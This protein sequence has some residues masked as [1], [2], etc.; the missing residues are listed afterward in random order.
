L[1]T[2]VCVPLPADTDGAS[3][4]FVR[5]LTTN[6][7]NSDEWIG[8]DNVN[9][10]AT[11]GGGGPDPVAVTGPGDK[12]GTVGS[13]IAAF[14][15]AATGGTPPYSWSATGLPDGVSI[16]PST[17]EVSGTPTTACACAVTATATDDADPAGTDDAAFTFTISEAPPVVTI[18]DIQGT[19]STSPLAGTSVTTE[20][21]VTA[22]YRDP[23]FA[24]SSY[25]GM[26]I[27][28]AGTG[29]AT[30]TTPG[31]SDAVFVYGAN[32]MPVGIEVGDSVSVTG[33]V[34]EAFSTT[35]ITPAAGGVVELGAPLAPVTGLDIAYPTTEADREAQEGM[36][37]APTDT[38]TVTNSYN[39]NTFAEVGLATGTEPLVQPTEVYRD[40]APELQTVKD[41][42][43]ARG[44]VLDDGTSVNY[45]TNSAAKNQPLPWLTAAGGG[46]NVIRVGA[47]AT[48]HQPVIL[49]YRFSTWR[50]QPQTPLFGNGDAVAT[51]ANTRP[52]NETAQPVGG[53]LQIATFNVL[54]YFNTTGEAYDAL[55]NTGCTFYD[56]R[57]GNHIGNNQCG[58]PAASNG[59]GPRGAA[60]QVSFE[61]QQAKIVNAINTLDADI[62]GLEEVENS[63]K[64]L[65]ET[66]RDDAVSALVAALNA[67]AGSNKW[68]YVKSPGEALAS[69]AISEQD[70]I[71]PAFIYQPATVAPVG[72]SDILFGTTEFT[73][74]R[75][76]LAQ[77]FKPADAPDSEAF[78]VI[79]NHFKSKGDSTPP[80]TGDN[81][82]S[83]DVG[84][85][86]GDRT[87]QATRLAQFAQ[88]FADARGIDAIFLAGDFNAYTHEDP[89][90]ALYDAGFEAIDS[91]DPT[92]ESYS[93]GGL[94]G[95]LDH[96]LGNAA[97][98]ALVT[99]ADVWEINADESI[100][101]QYSRY[102]YNLTDFWQPNLPFAASDHNPEVV[103]IDLPAYTPDTTTKVQILGT[104]DFHGRLLANGQEGG[105][106]VL[107]GA[108]KELRTQY[109]NTVFA[110][111]GDL[112]G[113]STFESFIQNDEP[114]I[115][116]LN[117][118]GLEVSAAGNH[119]FD[120]GYE[121]F[122]G[123]IQTS[124]NWEYIAANVNEPV[125]RDDL[126]ET[127][128]QTFGDIQVGF[129]GAVTED[130]PAL[131]SPSGIAGV[132]VSD[133]VDSTNAAAA[134]L[135]TGGADIVVLLVHE[136]SPS[137]DC[138]SASFTDPSTVWGNITQNVSADV[139]AIISGH[140]HLAY[141]CSF[142]VDDWVT[143]AR[144]VTKRPVVSSGQYGSNLNQLIFSVDDA[145]DEVM[146]TSQDV[147]GLGGVGWTP[148]PAVTTIVNDAVAQAETLGAVKLGEI[149]GP[150]NRAKLSGGSTEN[151]GG[152][153][154]LGNL[155]AEVQRWATETPEAGAAQIAFM[156]PGGLRQDMAGTV[157]GSFRDLTY[158]QA[159]VVQPFANTL[160][161][162]DLT[163]AQLET[164]LEQQ[165]QRTSGGTV[166]S[167]PFLR[168]GASEG[169]TY[170]YVET[171]VVV[172][173]TNTFEG[174]VTGMWLDGVAIDPATT[175]SVTVNSFLSSGGDNFFEFVNGTSRADTGKVDLEAMVDY[176]AEFGPAGSPLPVDY[177]QRAVE[178]EFPGAAPATYAPGDSVSF[179]VS[180][181]TMSTADDVKDTEIQVKLGDT[182]LG[183]ATL[184][185][186]IGTAVYDAYGTAAV[187]V[188]LPAELADGDHEL[189]LVGQQTGTSVPVPFVAEDGLT[190]VQ[191]LG[192][193]DFH[194]RL[195]VDG[196][197][198]A[199]DCDDVACPAA[200]LSGAVK[201]LRTENPNTVFAAA[202][203]LVGAST[204]ESFIQNDEPTIDALNE[205]GLEVSAAGNHEF[206]QGY[207][208]LVGRIQTSANWEYL[209]ANVNEPVGRDDLAETWTK[210]FGDITVGFVGAVTEELPAL[211]SPA[212]IE[213]VTVTDIVDATNAAAVD[214]KA[215][216]ADIVV[217][218]V[219]EGSPSTDCGSANFTD[220]ATVWGNI[221]QNVSADVDAIVSGHTHLA[222]NCSF[223]VQDWVDES[224]AVTQRPVVSSGQYGQNLNQLVFTVEDSTGDVTAKTQSVLALT[225]ANFTEDP[226]VVT[227][228]HDA[229][230]QADVLG[231]EVL[232]QIEAPLNRAKLANGTTENRGGESTLG[233][234]VAEVQRWATDTPETGSAQIA[235]MNPGG[236]RQDMAGTVNGD[237]RDVTYK[238]AAVV[239]PFANTLVNMDLTGAQIETVLEQQWQ[240]TADGPSGTV[241]SRPFLRLGVS[242]GFT[243]T[244]VET[245]VTVNGVD[246]FQGEVTGMWLNEVAI[247][248]ATSYSVTVN[249]FLSSGGDNFR[250]FTGGAGKADTGKIDLQA[251][252]DYLDEF[253]PV[254][255]PLALDYSQRA[256]EVEAVANDYTVG[257]DLTFDVASWTM[258]TAADVKDSEIVVKLGDTVLGTAALDNT[259]GTA[260]FDTY[261]TAQV[262]LPIPGSTLAGP[263]TLTLVGESTG[264]E[265]IVPITLVKADSTVTGEDVD[266]VYGQGASMHVSVS[267]DGAVP[268]GRVTLR[269]GDV[270][271]G[272]AQLSGGEA[273]VPIVAE[274]VGPGT[275]D[276]TI[277]YLGDGSVKPSTSTATLTVTKATPTVIGTRTVMEYGSG[278]LM[279]VRVGAAGV[280]P[281]GQV[282]LRADGV[283]LGT[284]TLTDGVAAAT[285]LA[286]RLPPGTYE[287]TI[288]YQG[289][290]FVKSETG[291]ATLVVQKA[292]PTVIGVNTSM[293]FGQNGA[294]TVKVKATGVVPT[295][296]VSLTANGV[297]LGP[298]ATLVDGKVVATLVRNRLP[299]SATPYTVTIKYSGDGFVKA[300]TGTASLTVRP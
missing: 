84:A 59:N 235:F 49:E 240:R 117:E 126:A 211:V 14:T 250:A 92:D 157:N 143:E 141:N 183:T 162:M 290:E 270:G 190:D 227:I 220:P 99:A 39:T 207:E 205:A 206:D 165:W 65:T 163:G 83:A 57:A 138:S 23:A 251:M 121:D 285:I 11:D 287:V 293:T 148:D 267:A 38:F 244:Y 153:S 238:Q 142:T 258:S 214:L 6:A 281:T 118:A 167:R 55:P 257:G 179:D 241:P 297:S 271:L 160:V 269:V 146:A 36:L 149:Q 77:A 243:Y 256:V 259:I 225:E 194:G 177:S 245:P 280:V 103:G 135:K 147:V 15:M 105:A 201:E 232:G 224:R 213:G 63:M 192:T 212:G 131:V 125:G 209:A 264:T 43:L 93:F 182:V 169:F 25:D 204:F 139:D 275:H 228:V 108:V 73:N 263:A 217:L 42:N 46:P 127:W 300:G 45:L 37:L 68:A 265:V 292:T 119:E 54:N 128:T 101:F 140:T 79:V 260:V 24:S 69:T 5:V 41:D 134:D 48:L 202:G 278:S 174:E 97:A 164:V 200:I 253:G 27:Q 208:D 124:A 288:T 10:T 129:V 274:R 272:Q 82:N 294:M 132:T 60:T 136:G 218:L 247:D 248:P 189:T 286:K 8:I 184:N 12:T 35:E 9:I 196:A 58:T 283:A 81:A 90:H 161:N 50:F 19:G 100:A 152:E 13:P 56:D 96:F 52:A 175:Y 53:D 229:K 145:T 113:A 203:D 28:T 173:G 289:D 40:D 246:T 72:A 186:T 80:A 223:T 18:A 95:S 104:N 195:L 151:R 34:S 106:A 116:A 284:G 74:A 133:I 71:R 216:G 273:D 30:D 291:T 87:R 237:A 85:F 70:V 33:P 91:D 2:P 109:P 88:D 221:T 191:I 170:T 172:S 22:M 282:T 114:T 222:Y 188:T 255:T 178:V 276:V 242:E 20:G 150:F 102:N 210:D 107:S 176:M 181:W 262:D 7:T 299:A 279:A 230:A 130:L 155:V 115:D 1:V 94:S 234:L 159:A 122:V 144:A 51:F 180:S 296:T 4:V 154:T 29:G 252:V 199:Q 231:A 197:S 112:V 187:S 16:N 61:R 226:A 261:G 239:Q 17:G 62:V 3:E 236:L 254:G 75:E 168:L 266:Q 219:H 32:S 64:L 249:S 78:A 86:N 47:E 166:P 137:T 66:N 268:S 111:A 26:Y 215:G 123:R 156:N 158:K 89:M 298:V 233:N 277:S 171:P 110:A 295:G 44:V 198:S 76:P 31:S 21:V 185:N 67:A 120:Q 193:N 98:V